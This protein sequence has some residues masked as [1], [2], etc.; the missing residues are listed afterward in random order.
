MRILIAACV[1]ALSSAVQA[2]A[3]ASS[4]APKL[5]QAMPHVIGDCQFRATE[6]Y[7]G[8]FSGTADDNRGGYTFG[9]DSDPGFWAVFM[10]CEKLQPELLEEMAGIRKE[11]DTYARRIQP[12]V[13]TLDY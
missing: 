11:R 5:H 10:S 12:V 7:D 2:P 4:I 1:L 13:A 6:I 8:R 9:Y 3:W